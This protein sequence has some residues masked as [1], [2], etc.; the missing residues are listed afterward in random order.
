MLLPLLPLFLEW[1]FAGDIDARSVA[2]TAALYTMAIA[3]S[4][5]HVWLLGV[6]FLW[7]FVFSAAFG[8]LS[9]DPRPALEHVRAFSGVAIAFVFAAHIIERFVRHVRK[10]EEFFEFLKSGKDEAHA[11]N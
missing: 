3:L 2:L 9:T 10:E 7:S 11:S 5:R 8:Y 1:W 4:S 6:G